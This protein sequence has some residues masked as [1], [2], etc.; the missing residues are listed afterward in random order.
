[1]TQLQT[2]Q[3]NAAELAALLHFYAD[4]GVDTLLEDAGID[5]FAEFAAD[6]ARAPAAPPPQAAAAAAAASGR[7]APGREAAPTPVRPTAPAPTIPGD[8]AIAMAR[9]VAGAAQT[10]EALYDAICAFE[11]CNLKTSAR[12]TVFPRQLGSL[13][14]LVIG[15][16]PSADDDRDGTPFSGAQGE[17]LD[18]MLNAIGLKRD[19][20]TLAHAIPWRPPGGRPPTP[21]EAEICRPFTERMISL[22]KPR[23]M[24]MLGNFTA[25]FLTG[26]TESIHALR[27]QWFSIEAGAT[28]TEA[29]AMLHPQ[30][31]M[32]A[33]LSKRLAWND[34][35]TFEAKLGQ[36]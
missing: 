23:H 31:L 28:T 35:L 33:P 17:L 34:L 15:P 13:P 7:R 12:S 11:G 16:T 1:M 25:R 3:L 5:R 22:I 21:A 10:L 6:R 29:L 26:S 27:G 36:N 18:R 4:A 8:E 2:E 24:I 30:D 32:V 14:I 20:L 9:K 19:D